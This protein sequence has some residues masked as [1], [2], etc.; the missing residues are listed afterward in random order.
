MQGVA[1]AI[2]HISRPEASPFIRDQQPTKASVIL[3]LKP[4]APFDRQQ[5]AAVVSMVAHAVEG[6]D[7]NNVSI[8][9]TSGHILSEQTSPLGS[10]IARQ[11]EYQQ[12]IETELASKAETML[13]QL[14]GPGRAVVRVAAEV[15]FTQTTRKE[16]TYDPDA[17]VKMYEKITT[18]SSKSQ[19]TG[20]SGGTASNV[21]PSVSEVATG[22][23][24]SQDDETIETEYL[25]SQTDTTIAE[26]AGRVQRL[27]ISAAVSTWSQ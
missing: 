11:F 27:T 24:T 21:T 2:V 12:R 16:T 9:D 13:S 19:P 14:L 4:G 26:A 15:D 7:P 8:T 1:Q 20:V 22:A 5:A 18:N 6:L 25:N 23:P 17:K 10:D 3:D